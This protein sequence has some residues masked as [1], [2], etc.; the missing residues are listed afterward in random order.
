MKRLQSPI[1][2]KTLIKVLSSIDFHEFIIFS[3]DEEK[4]SITLFNLYTC[5]FLKKYSETEKPFLG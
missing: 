5:Y 3:H 2:T 4:S 1:Q